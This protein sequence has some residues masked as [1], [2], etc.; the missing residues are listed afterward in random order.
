[1][2]IKTPVAPPIFK[3]GFGGFRFEWH[4]SQGK[5]YRV[6]PR[7]G[8]SL[9]DGVCIAEHVDTEARA[10]GSA[11]SYWRGYQAAKKESEHGT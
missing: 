4:I 2:S 10:I 11:Q 8:T 1:M 5:V 9:A 7:A 3:F 6:V